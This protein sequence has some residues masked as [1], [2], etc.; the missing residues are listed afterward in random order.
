MR[1]VRCQDQKYQTLDDFYQELA[2]EKE[3]DDIR[4]GAMAMQRLIARLRA[5]SDE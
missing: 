5:L 2:D 4:E 1:L 3:N